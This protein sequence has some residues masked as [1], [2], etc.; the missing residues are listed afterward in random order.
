MSSGSVLSIFLLIVWAFL[1]ATL[2]AY[3]RRAIDD[4]HEGEQLTRISEAMFMSIARHFI[5]NMYRSYNSAGP[6]KQK[7]ILKNQL[8]DLTH[9]DDYNKK[10]FNQFSTA[11]IYKIIHILALCRNFNNSI[12]R[13]L[14]SNETSDTPALEA[15]NLLKV[16]FSRNIV[17]AIFAHKLSVNFGTFPVRNILMIV[18][19][20]CI[21]RRSMFKTESYIDANLSDLTFR[22][23]SEINGIVDTYALDSITVGEVI[24]NFVRDN[25]I[26]PA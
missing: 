2:F 18:L 26:K 14:E 20:V 17:I 3:L 19:N 25:Q 24:K 23:F 16:S 8:I 21:G 5:Y 11:V 1:T 7:M 12:E 15:D 13:W 22:D 10:A 9:F 6:I 4:W